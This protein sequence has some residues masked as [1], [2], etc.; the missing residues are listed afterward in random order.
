MLDRCVVEC[1]M[2]SGPSACAAFE[3]T[4]D[5]FETGLSLMRQNLRRA[6]PDATDAE[7][8]RRLGEWLRHR[9]GAEDGDGCQHD[10]RAVR[11]LE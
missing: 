11:R 3:T 1:P 8:D 9:P 5:L 7:I 4:V 2:G 6:A 10:T